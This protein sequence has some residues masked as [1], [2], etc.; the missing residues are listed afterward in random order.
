LKLLP[1]ELTQLVHQAI[2]SAQNT[3]DLPAFDIPDLEVRPSKRADQGDYSIAVM[4]LN[5]PAKMNPFEIASHIAN[6]F[7]EPEFIASV[8]VVAPG[9][10]NFRLD[11][12]WLR[13]QVDS[14]IAEG[15]NLFALELG[16]GKRAQVE[17]VSAN[18][19]APL[20]IGRSRGA[21][22]GDTMARLLEA[23]GFSVEREYYFNNAGAQMRNLGNS[24][25][26]RYLEALGHNVIIPGDE[27]KTFYQGEYLKDFARQLVAEVG[28]SWIEKDWQPFKE[29]AEVKMFEMIRN[30]M[31]RIDIHHDV[32]FNENSLYD[33]G[34]IWEVLEELE[35]RG[36]VYKAALPENADHEDREEAGNGK[37]E[38]VW[39]RSTGFGDAKDRVLVKSSGE[40]TYT[41]PDIAYHVDKLNRGFDVCVNVLGA[42][43]YVQHQ[44]VKWGITALGLDASKIHVILLQLVL[45]MKDGE[46][47]KMTSRG[48]KFETLDSL[49]DQ[50]S[51]DAVRYLL[52]NRSTDSDMVFDIDLAV[53][54]S[55]E[56]P[57]YYIQYAHVRCAGIFREAAARGVTDDNADL[58][59]L[60]EPELRFMRKALE[61]GEVIELA[62]HHME[63]HRIA[64]Y[65]LELA[66]LFHPVFDNVRVLHSEVPPEVAKARLRF[67][68]AAQ[69][70]LKRVLRLMGMTA[71]EV[72]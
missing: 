25:K 20:H 24:L 43:H 2:Q 54:Q 67:F 72:M 42:D 23:A 61:L 57:V 4:A 55:N 14:I 17:F 40:P 48:G 5:K 44:V 69:V 7:Q 63:P 59:H 16:V 51:P 1:H 9:Y 18:P 39:F 70:V 19:T 30:T 68:R 65:A 21:I 41:L 62:V 3:G 53:K 33:S 28:D 31:V 66:N 38:A 47:I 13:Q 71:P 15:E 60:G 50:T 32:F 36:Y 8:E 34:A 10:V 58:K 37:G 12:D 22:V 35:Q 56:N 26:L 29:Y 64:F 11:D 52:L 46:I 45:L 27:D 49:I 6:H